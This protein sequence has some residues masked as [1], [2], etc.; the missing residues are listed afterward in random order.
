[1]GHSAL[2]TM[3]ATK[4]Q[5]LYWASTVYEST[6]ARG[7]TVI[8]VTRVQRVDCKEWERSITLGCELP[9]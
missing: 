4:G 5:C 7:G 1:M 6:I 3:E 2:V 8:E 9:L